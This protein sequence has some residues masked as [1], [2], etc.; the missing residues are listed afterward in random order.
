[1]QYPAL[2]YYNDEIDGWNRPCAGMSGQSGGG[3]GASN[4]ARRP[5]V[6]SV[7]VS[8][9]GVRTQGLSFANVVSSSSSSGR[10][11]D[12]AVAVEIVVLG[13]VGLFGW[14]G[15][16]FF[17]EFIGWVVDGWMDWLICLNDWLA[18]WITSIGCSINEPWWLHYI[19]PSVCQS[20]P[21]LWYSSNRVPRAANVAV[22]TMSYS[23]LIKTCS[24]TALF[25]VSYF[26]C[27]Y[28][29]R[30]RGRSC[31]STWT[32]GTPFFTSIT[33]KRRCIQT[34]SRWCLS[35]TNPFTSGPK[36]LATN[37]LELEC[38]S[39]CLLGLSD[40]ERGQSSWR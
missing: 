15:V 7:L 16:V 9:N 23:L 17:R 18:F 39:K 29:T 13:W 24:I 34:Y 8:V 38:G 37:C 28:S 30:E 25:P 26:R 4:V 40:F 6:G 11:V 10:S 20:N 1:M 14:R 19:D 12:C 22:P 36:R 32:R 35:L 5:C 33:W 2:K 3:G 27:N 21:D 31:S